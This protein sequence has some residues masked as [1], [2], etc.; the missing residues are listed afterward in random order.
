M[1]PEDYHRYATLF[2]A[3]LAMDRD[4]PADGCEVSLHSNE[5]GIALRIWGARNRL[6]VVPEVFDSSHGY[7]SW[8]ALRVRRSDGLCAASIITVH[9]Q[10]HLHTAPATDAPVAAAEIPF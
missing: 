3:V 2:D 5:A 1:R 6:D 9:L 7:G 8:T 10:D 4:R